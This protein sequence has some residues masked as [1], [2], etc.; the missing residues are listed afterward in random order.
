MLLQHAGQATAA[1]KAGEFDRIFSN[2]LEKEILI[3]SFPG[4][5]KVRNF[6]HPGRSDMV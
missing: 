4:S 2:H 3:R 6:R 1:L 5:V